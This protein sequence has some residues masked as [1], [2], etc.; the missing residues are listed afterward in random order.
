MINIIRGRSPK[1]PVAV[2][3]CVFPAHY[4]ASCTH[5]EVHPRPQWRCVSP[6]DHG[7]SWPHREDPRPQWRCPHASPPPM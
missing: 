3:M 6:T 5:K 4:G 7:A 1:A 2:S